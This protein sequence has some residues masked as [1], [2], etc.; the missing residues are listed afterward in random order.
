MTVR[1]IFSRIDR[2]AA[3]STN[4]YWR[5]ILG[6]YAISS[7][8][9]MLIYPIA[10]HLLHG[11]PLWYLYYFNPGIGFLDGVSRI[12]S[13]PAVAVSA[14]AAGVV[15]TGAYLAWIAPEEEHIRMLEGEI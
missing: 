6:A 4:F 14:P 11:D 9:P 15:A 3:A 1:D 7:T 5:V 10:G 8:V 13:D 2:A 12:F